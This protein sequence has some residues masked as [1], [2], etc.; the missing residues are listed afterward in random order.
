MQYFETGEASDKFHRIL[1]HYP[2]LAYAGDDGTR[3]SA[4]IIPH[5]DLFNLLVSQTALEVKVQEQARML[6]AYDYSTFGA[7]GRPRLSPLDD[8]PEVPFWDVNGFENAAEV[9]DLYKQPIGSIIYG[10]VD[11]SPVSRSLSAAVS[12]KGTTAVS[13]QT[14][15]ST[16]SAGDPTFVVTRQATDQVSGI[17]AT[18]PIARQ[19]TEKT[20]TIY[21]TVGSQ[22]QATSA[23]TS[24]S[25]THTQLP[26]QLPT[27]SG[28]RSSQA[29]GQD[30]NQ[31]AATGKAV[32]A[33]Q[34]PSNPLRRA[35]T[36]SLPLASG[37][38]VATTQLP[39]RANMPQIVDPGTKPGY[40][41][42]QLA[43][44]AIVRSQ[45]GYLSSRKVEDWVYDT[46]AYY[47]LHAKGSWRH[48]LTNS[49]YYKTALF[50]RA[51]AP[52]GYTGI[53]AFWKVAPGQENQFI[54]PDGGAPALAVTST[55]SIS[56][57]VR[58][59]NTAAAEMEDSV[60]AGESSPVE[61]TSSSST[62]IA[63]PN[64]DAH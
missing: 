5:V 3:Q 16:P 46:F 45:D 25:V 30:L 28:D 49:L 14:P 15:G 64:V 13:S 32:T 1:R 39:G 22:G 55:N 37:T 24:S 53:E 61:D 2:T 44:M 54:Y 26:A 19:P 56:P 35:P 63:A 59:A 9:I 57:G 34:P 40:Y 23:P 62:A 36:T 38:T 51:D 42:H 48:T 6:A 12:P 21:H 20:V 47:R 58:N 18:S 10:C 11:V 41:F 52:P 17:A 29:L 4:R 43:G 33:H 60:V 8:L 31:I 50:Q 7:A 27:S